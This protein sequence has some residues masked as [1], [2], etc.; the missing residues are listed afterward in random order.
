[1]KH[2]PERTFARIDKHT[3]KR[4][5]IHHAVIG[6]VAFTLLSSACAPRPT[7]VPATTVPPT[8]IPPTPTPLP[9]GI[10][11]PYIPQP[12]D[13]VAPV[14]VY[15]SPES[16]QAFSPSGSIELVFDRAM[17]QASVATALQIQPAVQGQVS[18]KDERTLSFKPAEALP[19]NTVFD[20]ALTQDAKAT[21]GARLAAPYQFRLTTQ[22]NLEAGQTIPENGATDIDPDTRITV[23][24]NRPVVPLTT[25]A[26]QAGL[27]QPLSCSPGVEGKASWLNTSILVFEPSTPFPGGT[28]FTCT[29]KGD[30]QDTEGNPMT[31]DFTWSFS[32]AAP[33]VT[34]FSFTK[35]TVNAGFSISPR[36]FTAASSGSEESA[37][38]ARVDTGIALEFNQP[39]DAASA[40][41]AFQLTQ[42]GAAVAGTFEVTGTTLI[43]TPTQRMNFDAEYQVNLAAGVLSASGGVGSKEGFSKQFTTVPLPQIVGT[44]PVD[45]QITDNPYAP[46][47]IKFNTEID[48]ATVMSHLSMTADGQTVIFTPT[49]VYTYF[50]SYNKTFV[51]N[52]NATPATHYD[53]TISP[54]IADP[55]GNLIE[56]GVSLSYQT[57]DA[58]P[59][60]QIALP[61]GAA[62]FDARQPVRLVAATM[63]VSQIE[64]ALYKLDDVTQISDLLYRYDATPPQNLL[65]RRF[66]QPITGESNRTARTAINLGENDGK[67]EPGMYLLTVSS[68]QV[69]D[70]YV[71]R[72]ALFVSEINLTLKSEPDAALVWATD[73]QTGQ[74]VADLT[75]DFYATDYRNGQNQLTLIGTS[76][77]DANGIAQLAN[78]AQAESGQSRPMF[79]YAIARGRFS[80]VST[81]WANGIRPYDFGISFGPSFVYYGDDIRQR[82]YLYTDRP[83]YRPDQ[84]V[85]I[86]GIVK[87]EDDVKYS[88]LPAGTNV[89]VGIYDPTGQQ[90][91]NTVQALDENGAFNLELALPASAALGAYAL[92]VQFNGN[93]IGASNFTVA[94]Y[95]PPEYEVVVTPSITEALRGNTLEA[96]IQSRYLS[97]GAVQ[98][99]KVSW[100]VLVR[101]A[102]FDPPQLDQYTFTDYDDPWRCTICWFNYR[103]ELPPQPILQGEGVT[104]QTGNFKITVP[105]STELRDA[106]GQIISGP[107]ELSI[108]A[109][110]TGA[111]N[112]IIAGRTS[113]I[114][115]PAEYYLGIGIDQNVVRANKPVTA[116]VIAVDLQGARLAGKNAEVSVYRREW[117]SKFVGDEFGGQWQT[118]VND[119]LI[120]QTQITG[121]SQGLASVTFT[122]T[123]A[124]SY[125]VVARATD[126]AGRRVQSSRFVWVTGSEYVS[127]LRQNNDQINLIA[128]KT[129]FVP[130]ETAQILIPSPFIDASTKE[131]L[132]LVTIERGHV[133]QQQ[134]IKITS[135][136][137]TLDV[138][139]TADFAPNVFVSVVLLKGAGII[140]STSTSTTTIPPQADYKVGFIGLKVEPV[141]QKL[142]VVLTTTQ[143]V[144][145]PGQAVT[146]T[147]QVRDSAGNP[148]AGQFSLDLVDK[149]ILNLMPRTADEILQAFYGL[150]MARVNTAVGLSVSGNR[151][152]ND[153]QQQY[154][155]GRGGGPAV[156]ESV[157][158]PAAAPAPAA[159]GAP[160]QDAMASRQN[161][162]N[163]APAVEVRENFADTGYWNPLVTTDANGQATVTITLPDNLTTWVLRAVGLDNETRVGE[164]T[165]NVVATKPLLIRPVTPRF[166]VVGDVV[167]LGAIINNN[168]DTPQTADVTL[169][170]D[171]MTSSVASLVF[172]SEPTQQVTIPAQSEVT[173]NWVVTVTD[174]PQVNLVFTVQNEQYSDASRPRLSTAPNGGLKVNK[175]SAP[176]VVGTAGDLPGEGSRTEIIGLPPN[177]DTTQGDLTVRLD[178]SLAASM[179][180]GLTYL[181]TFPYDCAEQLVSK[182]LPNVLTYRALKELGLSN[183][184]LEAK[185]PTLVTESLSRLTE[186][187]NEDGG[188]GWWRDEQSNPN[189]SAYVVFGMLKAREAGFSINNDTLQRG[190]TYL[191]GSLETL[192]M[193]SAFYQL[194]HQAYVLYVLAEA[195]SPDSARVGV[196]Y[197]LRNNLSHYAKA[198][199]ALAMGKQDA[200]D[201]RIKTLFADL[202]GAA[203]QSATGVHWEEQN[204]DWWAMNSNTRTTAMVLAAMV[205]LDPENNL[206]PNIVRWLMVARNA[207]GYWRSTQETAWSLIALTDWMR[208]TGELK[209]NYPFGAFLNETQIGGGQASS[210]TLTQTTVI[211]VPMATLLQEVANGLTTGSN[212]L[213]ISRGPSSADGNAGRLYYTAYLKAYFPVPELQA[214]D[215]GIAVQRR[216]TLASCTAGVECPEVTEAKIGDVIRVNLTLIAPSDLY[217][218]Q[219]EDPIP[220]GADLVDTGLATTSQLASGPTLSR[221][222]S[223]YGWWWNW[224]SRSE[225]RDD[226]VALF[227]SRLGKGTYEYSYTM[228][229][230]SV[231]K[232]NV[233]PT[234]VNQQY[235]PDVFGRSDGKLLTVTK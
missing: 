159:T 105:I 60:V 208:F 48:P 11:V 80:A 72:A 133:R 54:G 152:T 144:T 111:D 205:Q 122:P 66:T 232:F 146:Y 230:T 171:E 142:S 104:D 131:H 214:L 224:Y 195:G 9:E 198:L 31:G 41:A 165:V 79:S 132:A 8:A 141:P 71:Q 174:V 209:G 162:A 139:I 86:K 196:I 37:P 221:S 113:V 228:R 65:V 75:V 154:G 108:E 53:V 179:Q 158:A 76:A 47:V 95:R 112:Q 136:S 85:F 117:T 10:V 2:T 140:S 183:A 97:G 207:A 52:F 166:L 30:L 89:N 4:T 39:I 90:I 46:F 67:L 61:Y 187:Q 128:N 68:P 192:S 38:I 16:G 7:P 55:Y 130:G 212:R 19:R 70:V 44:Q 23:L 184:E 6:L 202:N 94:A 74:P 64:F 157:A 220:A 12:E 51:V 59:S 218:V 84:K 182:F 3:H 99:A 127:W 213:T 116:E 129:D 126:S 148:V 203:I 223:R 155:L 69:R 125:R 83:I 13:Q 175:W 103:P 180:A 56:Q 25:L 15:R 145:Q 121:D 147:L 219:L 24:F 123:Q 124:G 204:I 163:T 161:A 185:L 20:V 22:G 5:H 115:H 96:T 178:P 164:G 81:D 150:R 78:N 200:N 222:D 177:L 151:I 42:N 206:N 21:D 137:Q 135:S 167:E 134:V 215:R 110:V 93:F 235:F 186:I 191:Q 106:A 114:A 211:T 149:G 102:T 210:A 91:S 188:W 201:A 109:N 138:P 77:T 32:T 82:A 45:G 169:S 107:V 33:K 172:G 143:Q 87:A 234:F 227:A 35:S 58:P 27:P 217:Y 17:D 181:E 50:D 190:V 120:T 98:N 173:V 216:Y 225:L 92:Q 226:R 189:I 40:Q 101:G 168:T 1:M 14:V 63:N 233:I 160:A 193:Q 229:V 28:Q 156:A 29:V 153:L 197:D 119:E 170:S 49:Q 100:N 62:T 88:A 194:N 57:G 36:V 34:N 73:L 231:G 18:W 118:E 176:E 199:L 26:Q 43:F